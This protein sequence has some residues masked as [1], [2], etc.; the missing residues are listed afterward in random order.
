MMAAGKEIARVQAGE[1]GTARE[2]KQRPNDATNPDYFQCPDITGILTDEQ[3]VDLGRIR[4]GLWKIEE[5]IGIVNSLAADA[6]LPIRAISTN[7][8][9]LAENDISRIVYAHEQAEKR[10][11]AAAFAAVERM[12]A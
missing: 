3:F 7:P 1:I 6:G 4:I 10:I 5:L 9:A 8:I 11:A 12:A 2:S